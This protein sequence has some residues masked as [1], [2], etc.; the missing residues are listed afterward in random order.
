LWGSAT[1]TDPDSEATRLAVFAQ[2]GSIAYFRIAK[3]VVTARM[4]WNTYS[5]QASAA[6]GKALAVQLNAALDASIHASRE[7]Q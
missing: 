7:R 4:N 1:G 3:P 2:M 5:P 6:I